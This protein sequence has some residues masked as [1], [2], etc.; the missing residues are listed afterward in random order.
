MVIMRVSALPISSHQPLVSIMFRFVLLILS[1]LIPIQAYA[2]VGGRYALEPN[3]PRRFTVGISLKNGLCTGV[4][5]APDLILTAAHCLTQQPARHVIALDEDFEPRRFA[6]GGI[7]IHPDFVY[8]T[9]PARS[10]GPDLAL[11]RL[12]KALPGDMRPALLGRY[13]QGRSYRIAGFGV[14][15]AG[16]AKTAGALRETDLAFRETSWNSFDLLLGETPGG[17]RRNA[18]RGG[19][20]GDSGGP[21][22]NPATGETVGIVSWSA[23][24]RNGKGSCG[25]LTVSTRLN[26][27]LD[28]LQQHA[29]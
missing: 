7:T 15:R 3:G 19:C 2:V 4:V 17:E 12:A 25:G 24:P 20:S 9:S 13:I 8:A 18:P 23:G 27:H 28:W 10:K 5:I 1:L 29:R 11:I 26:E 22:F 6:I 21:V 16:A 14:M